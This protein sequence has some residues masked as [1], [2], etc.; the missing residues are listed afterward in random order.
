MVTIEI[1]EDLL[2]WVQ[3]QLKGLQEA[4]QR[5]QEQVAAQKGNG[6]AVAVKPPVAGMTAAVS[7]P[8]STGTSPSSSDGASPPEHQV[9]V[10]PK[11]AI[12]EAVGRQTGVFGV[13]AIKQAFW[14]TLNSTIPDSTIRR[15][16]EEMTGRGALLRVSQATGRAGNKYRLAKPAAGQRAGK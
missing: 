2:V 4:V 10:S 8:K 5:L 12:E 6:Q 16:L 9:R 1:S 13:G 11:L 14:G 7:T 3:S 15:L